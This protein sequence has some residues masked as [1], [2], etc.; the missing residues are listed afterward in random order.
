M[1]SAQCTAARGLSPSV[2]TYWCV[3]GREDDWCVDGRSRWQIRKVFTNSLAA[4]KITTQ[5]ACDNSVS[6]AIKQSNTLIAKFF[7]YLTTTLAKKGL[8]EV[9]YCCFPLFAKEY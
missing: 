1:I 4:G 9:G 7:S 2:W 3:D 8:K 5:Q 6:Y